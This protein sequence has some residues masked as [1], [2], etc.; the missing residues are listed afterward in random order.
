MAAKFIHAVADVRAA[1]LVPAECDST[2][3]LE[4]GLLA[5]SS[6][7]GLLACFHLLATANRAALTVGAQYLLQTLFQVLWVHHTKWD[8]GVPF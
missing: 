2:A 4:R 1:C 6:V 3:W 5:R 7:D 8:S